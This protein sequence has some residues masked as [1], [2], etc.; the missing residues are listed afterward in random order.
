MP[1]PPA[2]GAPPACAGKWMLTGKCDDAA[3]VTETSAAASSVAAAP[4][5]PKRRINPTPLDSVIF[6]RQ[7]SASTPAAQSALHLPVRVALRDV[8]ALVEALL[9]LRERQL[10]LGAAVL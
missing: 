6:G 7:P 9:A 1:S 3:D 4:V 5:H 2:N 10:D 8:A